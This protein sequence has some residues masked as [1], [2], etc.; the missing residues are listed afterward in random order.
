MV[1]RNSGK[2]IFKIS[3]WFAKVHCWRCGFISFRTVEKQED[4]QSLLYQQGHRIMEGRGWECSD[5]VKRSVHKIITPRFA[6]SKEG[7]LYKLLVDG[8]VWSPNALGRAL[9]ITRHH[10]AKLG[11]NL[12]RKGLAK[13][14]WRRNAIPTIYAG[15]ISNKRPGYKF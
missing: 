2:A 8:A 3:H 13:I 9:K 1:H 7:Q 11:R 6:L 4:L 15:R 14:K 5:C 10:V 12:E